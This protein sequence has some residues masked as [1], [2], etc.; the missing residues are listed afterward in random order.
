MMFHRELS[1]MYEA[2]NRT[3]VEFIIRLSEDRPG[4]LAAISDVLAENGVNIL[5]VSFNRLQKMI[6]V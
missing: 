3:I 2:G 6:H 5:N 1:M 4:I